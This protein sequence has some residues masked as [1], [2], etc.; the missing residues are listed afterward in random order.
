[1]FALKN[2]EYM[3]YS[4]RP[5]LE[6]IRLLSIRSRYVT[7]EDI[8]SQSGVPYA[9]VRRSVGRLKKAGRIKHV[10]HKHKRGYIYEV[11]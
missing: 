8:A 3:A 5:V 9:T 6:A 7:Y 2:I 10:A 11:V 1:M 4:D